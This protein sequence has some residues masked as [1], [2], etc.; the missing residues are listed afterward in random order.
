[1]STQAQLAVTYDISNDFFRLWLDKRMN[2]SCALFYNGTT[3]LED[4][5]TNK[6]RWFYEGIRLSQE[7]RVVDIGC[8][9][10]AN[11]EFLSKDMG[12]RDLTGI[13]LSRAQYEELKQ[14]SLPGVTVHCL[15]YKDFEP[16]RPFDAAVSIGMFEHLA[17][18][19]QARSGESLRIYR[20]YFRRVRNWTRPGAWFGLQTVIC[21]RIPRDREALQEIGWTTHS[22]F[23]GAIS[24][25]IEAIAASVTPYWEIMELHTRRKHYEKTATEWLR[26]LTANELAIRERWGDR[27]FAEYQRYLSAC[28]MAFREGYQSLA[29]FILRRVD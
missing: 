23:P 6:L 11:L 14:R 28:V 16:E 22:I 26:R 13:T 19:Q 27:I 15:S 20:D 2:Y 10:G 12:L 21:G 5:Q 7:S 25:R 29:Q 3:T 9:W 4:A 18:P 8:G 24:P 17:S 1:M